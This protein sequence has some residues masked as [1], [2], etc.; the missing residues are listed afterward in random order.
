MS[1]GRSSDSCSGKPARVLLDPIFNG[2]A[3]HRFGLEVLDDVELT[4]L[5]SLKAPEMP[6]VVTGDLLA[7]DR[8]AAREPRP[9]A[10]RRLVR[11][12]S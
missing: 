2:G 9:Q 12:R 1:A 6:T 10:D 8:R 4:H 5:R 7:G 3:R 11:P